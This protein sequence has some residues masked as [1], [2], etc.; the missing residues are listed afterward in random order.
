M[1]KAG[2]RGKRGKGKSERKARG[3]ERR[4]PGCSVPC[5]FGARG[6]RSRKAERGKGEWFNIVLPPLSSPPDLVQLAQS[7]SLQYSTSAT[8]QPVH[9]DSTLS[10]SP[11]PPFPS[12]PHTW[13]HPESTRYLRNLR[14]SCA[15]FLPPPWLSSATIYP[16]TSSIGS[17]IR[18]F[19]VFPRLP[20]PQ[21]PLPFVETLPHDLS[22]PTPALPT[23]STSC[24]F[25]VQAMTTP[26]VDK[27][28]P[29]RRSQFIERLHEYVAPCPSRYCRS[30]P[31]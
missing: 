12:P 4:C 24:N 26:A 17:S 10:Q 1:K 15:L 7:H 8:S 11:P 25:P 20:I 27:P 30:E 14:T 23:P 22:D 31:G 3:R 5:V 9:P 19:P 6:R 29:A 21:T 28:K 16:P 2:E 13:P 18:L